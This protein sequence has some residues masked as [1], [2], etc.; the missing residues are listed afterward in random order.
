[1]IR[2]EVFKIGIR[3]PRLS[4]GVAV[5]KDLAGR[6]EPYL[7]YLRE[8][9]YP[10]LEVVVAYVEDELWH[11]CPAKN[12]AA[13]AATTD[14]LVLT[15]LDDHPSASLLERTRIELDNRPDSIVLAMRLDGLPD[16]R[17]MPNPYAL[18]DWLCMRRQAFLA[19][20]GYNERMKPAA[21]TE[22]ELIGRAIVN[23][24]DVV[25]LDERVFHSWHPIRVDDDTMQRDSAENYRIVLDG[26]GALAILY[27]PTKG[28]LCM[29][30]GDMTISVRPQLHS[31]VNITHH[32]PYC[33]DYW[34]CIQQDKAIR[35]GVSKE[36]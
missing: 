12:A 34:D 26:G 7:R 28:L 15:G 32:L 6:V 11:E 31:V 14:Y 29:K 27:Y 17:A 35:L 4:I 16:Y 18:G 21:W 3:A 5:T 1:M 25:L 33:D 22:N 36:A 10:G 24:C 8:V 19:I 30:G 23:G 2:T 9:D 13:K 20:G